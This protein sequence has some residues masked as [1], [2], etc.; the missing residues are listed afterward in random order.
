MADKWQNDVFLKFN[1]ELSAIGR[2]C[3]NSVTSVRNNI[4]TMGHIASLLTHVVMKYGRS[5]MAKKWQKKCFF[6]F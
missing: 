4:Y 1:H 6:K 3:E 5:N 2:S